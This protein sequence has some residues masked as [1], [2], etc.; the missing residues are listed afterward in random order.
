MAV[1]LF[2]GIYKKSRH[3]I[4]AECNMDGYEIGLVARLIK[5]PSTKNLLN[6][7]TDTRCK[8]SP[9]KF[10]F[11][12]Y[13]PAVTTLCACTNKT[14]EMWSEHKCQPNVTM[15]DCS[16]IAF[17]NNVIM[18]VAIEYASQQSGLVNK[19]YVTLRMPYERGIYLVSV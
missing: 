9:S 6:L 14:K 16:A 8:N 11:M 12:Y 1:K 5:E 7:D 3:V 4:A 13:A 19:A 18:Q 17:Y 2:F 10:S 15:D